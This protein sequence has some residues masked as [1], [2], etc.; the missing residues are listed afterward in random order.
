MVTNKRLLWAI[1]FHHFCND[2]TLMALIAL[3]PILVYE[4][5]ISYYEVGLL[6]F[7]LVITVIV[8]YGVGKIADRQS[9]KFLLEAGA[10]LMASSFLLL[11]M[12]DD[13]PGLFAAVIVMR[14]GGAFYHP[15]GTSWITRA[16]GGAQLE[17]ALGVQSGVGNLGVIVALVSSGL[18]GEIYSWKEPCVLWAGLNLIAVAVGALVI[19][20]TGVKSSQLSHGERIDSWLTLRKI[21]LLSIPIMTGGALYQVTSYFGPLNLTKGDGWSAASADSMLAFWIAVGTVTSYYFGAISARFGRGW[22]LKT[23]YSVSCVSVLLLALVSHWY[24]V[25]A[26]LAVYGAL[27]F[28]TYPA[29]FAHVTEATA[30]KERGTAFGILFGLQLGGG[31]ATVYLCGIIADI[32]DD[33]AYSFV[34]VSALAAVSVVALSVWERGRKQP[35]R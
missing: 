23:A 3:V 1:S 34:V 24:L 19:K 35:G 12:V 8:Q 10:M 5:D 30:E 16:F 17:T 4:M 25:A 6:G 21:G 33:P 13:F 32:L 28:I 9:S 29:L 2:G 18:L 15:V 26:A 20:E 22:L 14:V 7:G 27:L 31:A 11:L